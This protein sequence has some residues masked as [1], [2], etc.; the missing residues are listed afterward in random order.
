MNE[1]FN[2]KC[3]TFTVKYGGGQVMYWGGFSGSGVGPLIEVRGTLNQ[4][5]YI[6]LL[7]D[8]FLPFSNE[9][10]APGWVFQQDN[11]PC[12]KSKKVLQWF[13]ANGI[14]LI[15]WP[16]QSPD[17]NPIENLWAIIK[18]KIRKEKP[19]NLEDL[20]CKIVETW[21]GIP[22]DLCLKLT[23][24]MPNRLAKVIKNKGYAINY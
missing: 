14:E 12:H 10:L 11:A 19:K 4:N 8:Q 7:R 23:H 5:G 20:K 3:V 1:S 16:A 22:K 21:N 9:N 15:D 17:L 18:A 6:D 13:E 2:R 24:S